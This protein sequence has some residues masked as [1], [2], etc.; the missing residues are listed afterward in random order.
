MGRGFEK[1]DSNRCRNAYEKI[2]H[3]RLDSTVL[4]PHKKNK[5]I[6]V[7][8]CRH[9]AIVHGVELPP[10]EMLQDAG[11][12]LGG[13]DERLW[14]IPTD[15]KRFPKKVAEEGFCYNRPCETCCKL[16]DDHRLE[17]A[18]AASTSSFA[19]HE[20]PSPR[21]SDS[22]LTTSPR[23]APV[24]SSSSSGDEWDGGEEPLARLMLDST[25]FIHS[26]MQLPR[27]GSPMARARAEAPAAPTARRA[28]G[29][30]AAVSS[31]QPVGDEH[32]QE[33]ADGDSGALPSLDEVHP[34]GDVGAFYDDPELE[35]TLRHLLASDAPSALFAVDGTCAHGDVPNSGHAGDSEEERIDIDEFM[36]AVQEVEAEAAEE[37]AKAAAADDA[38]RVQLTAAPSMPTPAIAPI[39]LGHVRDLVRQLS[40][41]VKRP[42]PI[43]EGASDVAEACGDAA[44]IGTGGGDGGVDDAD[45]GWIDAGFENFGGSEHEAGGGHRMKRRRVGSERL[46]ALLEELARAVGAEGAEALS[47]FR[48]GDAPAMPAVGHGDG[49]SA[50]DR[51]ALEILRTR[52]KRVLDHVRAQDAAD[53]P[54]PAAAAAGGASARDGLPVAAASRRQELPQPHTA[55]PFA[56][57]AQR[58]RAW[59]G[60]A[61]ESA[62]SEER[63]PNEPP[64]SSGGATAAAA[65]ADAAAAAAAADLPSSVAPLNLTV[66]PDGRRALLLFCSPS[67]APLDCT[68]EMRRLQAA[69]LL[70]ADP[71]PTQGGS[72]DDLR[73]ALHLVKPHVLWFAGHGDAKQLDGRRTL[74]FSGDHGE[75]ELFDPVALALELRPHLPIHGGS[76]E[77]VVL[78]AC[79]TGGCDPS[80]DPAETRLGDLL[81]QIG[82]P[83]VVCWGS[84]ADNVACAHFA[85]GLAA[86]L[87]A[88]GDGGASGARGGGYAAA[89]HRARCEVLAVKM[90]GRDK[91][92]VTQR[93]E[94]WDPRD[95]T[96]VV[97]PSEAG[98]NGVAPHDVYRLRSGVGAGRVAA[99]VPKLLENAAVPPSAHRAPA[100]QSPTGAQQTAAAA[101][102]EAGSRKRGRATRISMGMGLALA[103]VLGGA[104]L[105]TLAG[106][107]V[108]EG[109]GGGGGRAGVQRLV[110]VDRHGHLRL[111]DATLA[112]L[113]DAPGPVCVVGVVGPEGEGSTTFANALSAALGGPAPGALHEQPSRTPGEAALTEGVR[114]QLLGG[115]PA[116]SACGTTLVLDAASITGSL[117][118]TAAPSSGVPSALAPK[119]ADDAQHRLFTFLMLTT[120]RLVVNARRAPRLDLLERL[121]QASL[122]TSSVRPV[123]PLGDAEDGA[124]CLALPTGASSGGGGTDLVMLLR[125]TFAHE[126]RQGDA[127]LSSREV[128]ERWLPGPMGAAVDAAVAS[129]EVATLEAPSDRDLEALERGSVEW[130]L[131]AAAGAPASGG[132]DWSAR[133]MELARR[134]SSGFREVA[135]PG[136]AIRQDAGSGA[137]LAV[138][139]E[140]VVTQLNAAQRNIPSG[141]Q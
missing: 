108:F 10:Y 117:D 50:E 57:A 101:A 59:C 11:F 121:V 31:F 6:S 60:G 30:P 82:C 29:R 136:E 109:G 7:G 63:S 56:A 99:G 43:A 34:G 44:P 68:I 27:P 95:A 51:R 88:G 66:L 120:S 93:F 14:C 74:G 119:A 127:P 67:R 140:H 86:A 137:A 73:K 130:L 41:E 122:A 65:A 55:S 23:V 96:R 76:L 16:F 36:E 1:G 79:G 19:G 91:G 92:V 61:T 5:H 124:D 17:T 35:E 128:L 100:E 129:W 133:L 32:C 45:E 83:S 15:C 105:A 54:P 13:V 132:S 131:E 104:L 85:G 25:R 42:L 33:E 38:A 107:S 106:S 2:L 111:D 103:L 115:G 126:L 3:D 81:K 40:S 20:T 118:G 52:C 110:G 87:T 62:P 53:A 84:P 138:W 89:F 18:S 102:A 94:F 77:C 58:L 78:N 134:L 72:F 80:V 98:R 46:P 113:R 28:A 22:P 116:D 21:P 24:A 97:Q 125:D 64:V 26:L 139:M 9:I 39:D 112:A 37:A 8:R 69:G 47:V 4:N 123:R 90:A 48:S 49:L 75:I 135:H 71:P 12:E 114:M 141:G 70:R